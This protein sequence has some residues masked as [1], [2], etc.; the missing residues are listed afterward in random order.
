MTIAE[1]S[2]FLQTLPQSLRR[3]FPSGEIADAI[4]KNRSSFIA[5]IIFSGVINILYLTPAI[6]MLQIYDRVLNGQSIPTLVALT[7][8]VFGLFVVLGMLEHYRSKIMTDIGNQIDA[9]LSMR[10]FKAAFA[11]QSRAPESQPGQTLWDLNQVRQFFSGPGLFSFVD[12]PW[13]P[14]FIVV[15]FLLHPMLGWLSLSGAILLSILTISAER[16]AR[17]KTSSAQ[18][19][20]IASNGLASSQLKNTDVIS[21]MGMLPRL[22]KRWYAMHSHA[23]KEQI[24]ASDHVAV[25]T[26]ATRVLRLVLQSSI[27]G[28]GAFLVIRGELSAGSMIAATI[29]MTRALSPLESMLAHWK[30]FL[31]THES[32][33]RLKT[34]LHEFPEKMVGQ[35]MPNITGEILA[36]NIYVTPPNRKSPILKGVSFHIHSGEVVAI[37]GASAAG[38]STLGRAILGIWPASLGTIRLNG[39]DITRWDR[40]L[41]GQEVGYLPQDIELFSG[42]VSQNICRFDEVDSDKC[43]KAATLAGIHSTILK[44]PDG[45]ETQIGESGINLSGGQRQLLGLTR[46]I[47]GE[48]SLVVLDEPDSSLDEVGEN[49]LIEVVH[50]LKDG[51]STLILITHEPKLLNAVDRVLLIRDGQ[52]HEVN[53]KQRESA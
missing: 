4:N 20:S 50:K 31:S 30:S 51:G 1:V 12:A 23:V 45:Y 40:E 48:P 17:K 47:Y 53:M 39:S 3:N 24:S 18:R 35:T 9:D 11:R 52:I 21:A 38:K 5:V 44:M 37:V 7:L 25:I 8:L 13:M 26:G 29:L 15:I 6:Y 49:A 14:I 16:L 2:P 34:L 22:A 19:L 33:K 41:I 43:I 27:L 36:E 28:L 46:A 32:V 10:V 42:T